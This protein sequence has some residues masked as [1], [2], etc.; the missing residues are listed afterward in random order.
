[1][2]CP[3]CGSSH[4]KPI[5]AGQSIYDEIWASEDFK[6]ENQ[7]FTNDSESV[8]RETPGVNMGLSE[9]F[10]DYE[11]KNAS[12]E[13]ELAY[14]SKRLADLPSYYEQVLQDFEKEVGLRGADRTFLG[15]AVLLQLSRQFLTDKLKQR[16]PDQK[17]AKNTPG[18]TD[19]TSKRTSRRY[20]ASIEEIITNPVPFDAMNKSLTVKNGGNPLLNGRNH[21]YKALGHDPVFGFLFGTANIMTKTITVRESRSDLKT[22]MKKSNNVS[23]LLRLHKPFMTYHVSTDV[24]YIRKSSGKEV[25]GDVISS[26]ARTPMMFYKIMERIHNEGKDG[27]LALWEATKKEL[28]HLLSDVRTVEGVPIPGVSLAS[29]ELARIMS[30]CG[31]DTWNILM[32]EVDKNVSKIINF[33]ISSL[34]GFFYN[35]EKDGAP[36]LYF[37]RTARIVSLSNE[38]ASYCNA[39]LMVARLLGGDGSAATKFD[40]GGFYVTYNTYLNYQDLINE[41]RQEYILSR[42]EKHIKNGSTSN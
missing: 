12:V 16:L 37:A 18:H 1:M 9:I 26:H 33:I 28:I 24:A 15:I 32:F 6:V 20:Y 35:P 42:L 40:F 29:P 36:D 31:I 3:R 17:A 4:T 27:W 30:A 2:V 5:L 25:V 39:S 41:I 38:I 19:E 23:R 13:N 21:R 8:E 11:Q 22:K 7:E 34:H 14:L 10:R